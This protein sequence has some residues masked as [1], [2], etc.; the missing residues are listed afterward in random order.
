[1]KIYSIFD[2][3]YSACFIIQQ[4]IF[5]RFACESW[6]S[7][8]L[9]ATL[10]ILAF[11]MMAFL[12][13]YFNNLFI[14]VICPVLICFG[15]LFH[16]YKTNKSIGL[17]IILSNF[18]KLPSFIQFFFIGYVLLLFII[19]PLFIILLILLNIGGYL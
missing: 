19:L 2:H 4:K 3:I 16:Y 10:V 12:N 13:R 5:G 9:R 6:G 11:S 8:I 18:K 14:V 7:R 17:D 15:P 1:M